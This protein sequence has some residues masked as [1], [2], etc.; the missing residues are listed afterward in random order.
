VDLHSWLR[1][2]AGAGRVEVELHNCT[3][4][5]NTLYILMLLAM[6]LLG[7]ASSKICCVECLH[8]MGI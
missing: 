6:L 8:R 2:E 4:Q 1:I 5:K 7:R 3:I